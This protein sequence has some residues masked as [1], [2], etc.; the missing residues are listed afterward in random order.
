MHVSRNVPSTG[1]L[2]SYKP[3][4]VRLEVVAEVEVA[5]TGKREREKRTMLE[6]ERREWLPVAMH[7]AATKTVLR[8]F[9][10]LSG[11]VARAD[12]AQ[13]AFPRSDD[14]DRSNARYLVFLS[15]SVSRCARIERLSRGCSIP[16]ATP[17]NHR[18][19]AIDII[20]P[21]KF[22]RVLENDGKCAK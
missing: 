8:H 17:S 2:L 11:R 1:G 10:P 16:R 20:F 4:V 21:T 12:R 22:H 15:V 13:A 14:Q 9:D 19:P 3:P 6:I 18:K 5:S 7:W